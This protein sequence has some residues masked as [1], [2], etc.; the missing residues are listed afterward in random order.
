MKAALSMLSQRICCDNFKY[1]VVGVGLAAAFPAFIVP[2]FFPC[3]MLCGLGERK[4]AVC[5]RSNLALCPRH[6]YSHLKPLL[7]ADLYQ[8]RSWG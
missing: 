3:A 4:K 5:F 7:F 6:F 2:F 1:T 8:S